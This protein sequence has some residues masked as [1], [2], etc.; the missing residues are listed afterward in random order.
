[1]QCC[2]GS[3]DGLQGRPPSAGGVV[4]LLHSD[5]L[6]VDL[7]NGIACRRLMSRCLL[8]ALGCRQL[9]LISSAAR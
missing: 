3:G 9:H 4:L 2:E 6:P 1:M 7:Q 8:Q 5:L